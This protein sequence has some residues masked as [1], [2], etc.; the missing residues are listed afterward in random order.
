MGRQSGVMGLEVE[1]TAT[2]ALDLLDEQRCREWLLS[3]VHPFGPSCPGCGGPVVNDRQVASWWAGRRVCCK[4]CG[5][6][7]S[8]TTG[9]VLNKMGLSFRQ[10]F[11]LLLGLDLNLE[12]KAIARLC[13][14]H[15]DTVRLWRDK[16]FL[17]RGNNSAA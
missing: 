7:F 13:A 2:V 9:T 1:K 5:K 17:L 6:Y 16:I 14:C 8:A 3:K 15:R 10:A 11:L 12:I 4:C